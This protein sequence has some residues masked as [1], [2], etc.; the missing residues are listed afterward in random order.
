MQK[1][2]TF[3]FDDGNKMKTSPQSR[4]V[5]ISNQERKGSKHWGLEGR[6]FMGKITFS[7]DVNIE[8]GTYTYVD[9]KTQKLYSND[10]ALQKHPNYAGKLPEADIK[11]LQKMT[12]RASEQIKQNRNTP[13]KKANLQE[14]RNGYNRNLDTKPQPTETKGAKETQSTSKVLTEIIRRHISGRNY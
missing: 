10:P 12:N 2:H 7:M 1:S 3:G 4:F 9:E 8:T 5:K 6:D 14:L 11:R 13:T